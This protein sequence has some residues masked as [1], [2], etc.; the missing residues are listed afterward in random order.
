MWIRRNVV[1][2]SV[3]IIVLFAI[4]SPTFAEVKGIEITYREIFAQGQTFGETGCYEVIKGRLFYEIDPRH[5]ANKIIV[6]IDLAPKNERGWVEFSGDFILL[7]PLDLSKGNHR[8]LYDVNN[9]GNLVMLG[10]LN[11]APFSNLPSTSEHAGNGFLMKEGYSLLWTAWNWDVSPGDDRL[12][13]D[14]PIATEDGKVISQQIAS[15]IVLSFNPG[16][17][18]SHPLAWGN[19]RCYPPQ[20]PL[21]KKN[22]RLTVRDEPR[23]KRQL[24]PPGEWS[25]GRMQAGHLINDPTWLYLKSGFQPGKIYELIYTAANPRIVGLGLAGVRDALSF[26]RWEKQDQFGRPNPLLVPGPIEGSF[27]PDTRKVYIFGVSQSGRF[28]THMIYQGFH[29]NKRGQMVFDGARIHVAGGGKGGFNFRFAQTTHHPSHLEGNYMPADFFPFNFAKQKDPLTGNEGDVLAVAK[30]SGN[31]PKIMITNNELEYWTRSASLI[32]T[33]VMGKKDAP[34]HENV[35]IYFT[36]GA[37][38]R[39]VPTRKRTIYEHSLNVLNHYPISRALLRA[40]D[41][42]H[43]MGDYLFITSEAIIRENQAD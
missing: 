8:L 11:D 27:L 40:L 42:W 12:Q 31:I 16:P 18:D 21:D 35:R 9:R 10:V 14:V 38:H 6:D 25:F 1:V 13:M 19:S 26:F 39:N 15:E 30:D 17:V 34:V 29:V 23:G 37:P 24:I 36:A 28:I 32:H 2:L 41:A 4:N 20:N 5:P 22:A 33:D 3:L 43:T 7:K